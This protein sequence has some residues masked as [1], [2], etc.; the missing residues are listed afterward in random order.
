MSG[1]EEEE[2]E[3]DKA[4]EE[5]EAEAPIVSRT[6]QF[7][8]RSRMGDAAEEETRNEEAED[9]QPPAPAPVTPEANKT[10]PK[11]RQLSRAPSKS[12]KRDEEEFR[13]DFPPVS[14]ERRGR[15]G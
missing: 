3:A 12:S 10:N 9:A 4:Q 15:L 5:E 8:M 1:T 7:T 14:P 11:Q 6:M 13:R 2:Q